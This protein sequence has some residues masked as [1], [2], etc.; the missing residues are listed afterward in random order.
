MFARSTLRKLFCSDGIR[1]RNS[2]GARE[3]RA[4]ARFFFA[5]LEEPLKEDE[6]RR[7]LQIP[8]KHIFQKIFDQSKNREN[9]TDRQSSKTLFEDEE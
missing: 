7:D 9:S 3:G 2:G 8:K 1:A 6:N 5:V 4:T